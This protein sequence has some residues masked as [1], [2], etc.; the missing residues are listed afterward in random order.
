MIANICGEKSWEQYEGTGK[1]KIKDLEEKV[2]PEEEE[3]TGT[4]TE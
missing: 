4:F 2:Q 3:E 1:R